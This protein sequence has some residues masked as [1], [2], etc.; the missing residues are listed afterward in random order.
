L[1]FNFDGGAAPATIGGFIRNCVVSDVD[2]VSDESDH[3]SI[4]GY[5]FYFLN[6][7]VSWSATKQKSISLSSTEA[8]YYF[9]TH[10][11]KEALWIRLLLSLLSFPSVSPF[12]LLSD[13]QS[14]YSLANNSAITSHSKHIDICYH[15]I[16]DHI[17]DGTFC[18]H[19][20]PTADMPTNIFT[21]PLPLLLFLKHRTSLG[22]VFL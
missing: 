5:C 15:F 17:T 14:A 8:E 21:K 11:L 3:R 10:A 4:L 7:L 22:L 1:E 6:S 20:I 9:M 13:N 18:T 19:W 16:H 12:P 2:W